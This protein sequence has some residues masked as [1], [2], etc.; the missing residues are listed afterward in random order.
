MQGLYEKVIRR[1]YPE[2][3]YYI[4]VYPLGTFRIRILASIYL[5][6][7]SSMNQEQSVLFYA[8]AKIWYD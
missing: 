2:V 8:N 4:Q 1:F 3:L 5:V 7:N 6:F